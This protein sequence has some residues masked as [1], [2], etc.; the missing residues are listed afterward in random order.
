MRSLFTSLLLLISSLVFAQQN[1]P[2]KLTVAAD[3]SGDYRT[4][5]EAINAF[6]AYSP[7]AL[8]L[9]I[10]NGVYKEKLV[11]PSWVTNLTI[12]GENPD[13]TIITNDD[14]SGKFKSKDTVAD[15]S[16]YST[17][18]SYTM[19]VQGNDITIKNLT[20]RNTAGRVGQAVALHVDGD[21]V[22]V[23]NCRLLGNQDTLL[24][25]NDSSRQYYIGCIIE[26]TTD[27]IFG[28]ATVVFENC[29]IR[30]LSNSYITAAST[31]AWKQFGY[32][33]LNCK[34]TANEEA[35]QVYLGRPWRAYARTVFI[36]CEMGAHI[37]AEGWENWR[38]PEN[39]KTAFYAEYK[40]SGPGAATAGR[41]AWSHQLTKKQAAAYTTGRIF[42]D[43]KPSK[44]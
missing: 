25:A 10:R 8:Q 26:G 37:R 1:Y 27:F 39:E 12:T 16:K 21:R 5:Q 22:T 43:W 23:N 38:N 35:K 42:G 3:G 15:K 4:I 32:V 19:W 29:I 2:S 17:F 14:Y 7:V 11:I 44:N 24:T 40:N 41:V 31:P 28:P 30:S 34:L 20:I 33:F 36:G 13:S 6:R 9:H 18:S